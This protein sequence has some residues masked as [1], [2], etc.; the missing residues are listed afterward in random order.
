MSACMCPCR[1][2]RLRGP[3]CVDFIVSIT[4][5]VTFYLA[6]QEMQVGNRINTS[7]LQACTKLKV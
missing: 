1:R 4:R 5:V 3:A 6:L 7:W 2:A